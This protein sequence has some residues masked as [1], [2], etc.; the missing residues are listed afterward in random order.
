MAFPMKKNMG[1]P[2]KKKPAALRFGTG[3]MLGGTALQTCLLL[4][5]SLLR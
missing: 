3:R 4:G 1:F 2:E 5:D